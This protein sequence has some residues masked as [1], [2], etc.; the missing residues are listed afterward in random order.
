M[1]MIETKKAESETRCP[2]CEW[3]AGGSPDRTVVAPVPGHILI[4]LP[5]E[6]E[7]R[8]HVYMRD[9]GVTLAG[10]ETMEEAV[11][12]LAAHEADPAVKVAACWARTRARRRA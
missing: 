12:G 1:M 10:A 3:C 4:S 5:R 11:L 9:G 8:V 2:P 7:P 6:I